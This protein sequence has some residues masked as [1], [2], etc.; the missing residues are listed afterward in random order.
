MNKFSFLQLISKPVTELYEIYC[1]IYDE[2]NGSD[3]VFTQ[4]EEPKDSLSLVNNKRGR[5]T[6]KTNDSLNVFLEKTRE[7]LK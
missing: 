3:D 7:T 4:V 2:L 5:Y 6:S 1:K